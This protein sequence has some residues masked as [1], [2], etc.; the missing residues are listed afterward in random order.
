M[1]IYT[2][3][4]IVPL[5]NWNYVSAVNLQPADKVLIVPL[6]NWNSAT[7][8]LVSRKDGFNRTFMELKYV[9]NVDGRGVVTF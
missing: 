3:V 4:L 9:C 8:L 5:W 1:T 7:V 6:W 2:D